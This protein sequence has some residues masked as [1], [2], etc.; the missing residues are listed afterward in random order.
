[1]GPPHGLS[2]GLPGPPT[3]IAPQLGRRGL[4]DRCG[5]VAGGRRLN[6]RAAT[7]GASIPRVHN[8]R[9]Q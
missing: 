8:P 3:D 5:R 9:M 1:M 2:N 4:I 6:W 7:E